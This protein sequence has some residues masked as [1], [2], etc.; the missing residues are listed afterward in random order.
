MYTLVRDE[1]LCVNQ[2]MISSIFLHDCTIGFFL[3]LQVHIKTFEFNILNVALSPPFAS[4]TRSSGL[5]F[6]QLT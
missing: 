6:H 3:S 5:Q 1:L 2:R 4:S